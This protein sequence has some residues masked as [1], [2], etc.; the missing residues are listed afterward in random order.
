[1]RRPAPT[2]Q[3]AVIELPAGATPLDFAYTLH[4]SVGH[5]CR[6]AR[7]DSALVPLHTP[8]KNGQTVEIITAKDGG[9]S[10]DWLGGDPPYLQSARARSKVRAWFHAQEQA[11]TIA[12][13]RELVEKLLQREGRT[14]LKLEH[15]AEQLGFKQADALF[16]AVGKEEYSLHHI[17][18]LLRP[19]APAPTADEIVALRRPRSERAAPSAGVL[20]VGVESLLTTLSRCCRPAPPDDIGGFVTRGKGVAIHRSDCSNLKH[21]VGRAPERVIAVEWGVPPGGAAYAVDL[22]LEADDRQGLLR[23]ISELLAKEKMNVR[24]VHT[25]SVSDSRGR[26]AWMTFTVEVADTRRLPAV[27]EKVTHIG[28]VRRAMRK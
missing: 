22:L 19:P 4:T 14:A 28:G 2:P 5:R 10:R 11:L 23:D 18:N 7:V 24:G 12:R 17:E 6:G 26:T 3:A 16:E 27:L 1:M 9:P 21:M 8:L 15:L 13:G 25:H 20:V